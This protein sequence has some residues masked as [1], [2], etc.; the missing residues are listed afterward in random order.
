MRPRAAFTLRVKILFP[1]PSVVKPSEKTGFDWRLF[2]RLYRL[3]DPHAGQRRIVLVMTFIRAFQRPLLFWALAAV[4][5]GAVAS[6][7]YPSVLL[8][9]LGY[10]ALALSTSLV[11][12]F[13]QRNQNLLGENLVH[14]LRDQ[15]F[16]NLQRQPLGYFHKTKLGRILSR[17]VSDLESVRRGV[18]L[19][20]FIGQEFLQLAICGALMAWYSWPLFLVIL[21]FAPL[22][23]LANRHFHPRIHRF[24]RTA[25]ES[26]SRLTGSL[27]ESIRGIR[28]IQGYTRQGRGAEAFGL[29]V[30]R[31][32][33]DNV[34]LATE[35]ALYAPLLGLTG[36]FFLA[37]LLLV[38]G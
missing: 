37:A 16:T 27:A 15:I 7:R 11:A 9:A 2:L 24:S 31:L 1:V 8:G 20:V 12:H 28:V 22:L 32:A 23:L 36:Q 33:D 38:G 14:D 13:R 34:R 29:H 30:D 17:V 26:S 19:V 18:Q 3:T 4:V 35:S 10:L 21:A 6:G 25:A 5:N